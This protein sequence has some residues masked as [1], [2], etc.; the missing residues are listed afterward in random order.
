MNESIDRRRFMGAAA[1]LRYLCDCAATRSRRR[2]TCGPQR[3]DHGGPYRHG[4]PGIP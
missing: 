4:H 1:F 3:K 2:R